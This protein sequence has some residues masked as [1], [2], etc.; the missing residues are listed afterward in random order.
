MKP[1]TKIDQM[2]G[3]KPEELNIGWTEEKQLRTSMAQW[4]SRHTINYEEGAYIFV[5]SFHVDKTII[6]LVRRRSMV[7]EWSQL[8][9]HFKIII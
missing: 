8:L 1:S 6:R 7:R 2:I 9:V 5:Q 4:A 3:R